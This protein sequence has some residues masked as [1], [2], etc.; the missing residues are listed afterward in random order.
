M[1]GYGMLLMESDLDMQPAQHLC[2]ERCITRNYAHD[3]HG[4]TLNCFE[5]YSVL[6]YFLF[7]N[8]AFFI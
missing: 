3:Q 4:P 5:K 6:K 1:A 2:C 8:F 7:A